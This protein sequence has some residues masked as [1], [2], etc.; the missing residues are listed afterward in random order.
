MLA[1]LDSRLTLARGI[2]AWFGFGLVLSAL[3]SGGLV[4]SGASTWAPARK[5]T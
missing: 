1:R 3:R 5:G 2:S 4:L